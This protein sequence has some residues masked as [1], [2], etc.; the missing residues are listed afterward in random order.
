MGG[1]NGITTSASAN[2]ITLEKWSSAFG[3]EF[4]LFGD[5]P[6]TSHW[7]SFFATLPVKNAPEANK[8]LTAITT[9]DPSGAEWTHREMD[10]VRYFFHAVGRAVLFLFADPRVVGPNVGRGR[11]PGLGGSG[12]EEK[13]K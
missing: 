11:R 3:S 9:A 4:G 2:G 7:P 10:G 6:A 13:C 8:I 12:D 5:W 1:L